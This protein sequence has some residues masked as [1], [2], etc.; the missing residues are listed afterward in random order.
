[1]ALGPTPFRN[2]M[3]PFGGGG[4]TPFAGRGVMRVIPPA[5]LNASLQK[6]DEEK[7]KA[8][9]ISEEVASSL[10]GFIRTQ[11]DEFK[12]HR[13]GS[14]G[15]SERLLHCL[16]VFNGQYDASKIQEIKQFGGSEVYARL[17]SMKCRGA[18][19]L[20]RDVYL[21]NERPW[22][23]EPPDDPDVP[24]EIIAAISQLVGVEAQHQAAAGEP[25][26]AT[27]IRDRTFSLMEAARQAA[28]KRAAAQARVAEDKIDEILSEGKFYEALAAFLVDLPMFPFACIKGPVVK[29]VPTVVWKGPRATIG[30]KPRLFW[31]RV[32]PFDIWWTPGCADIEDAAVIE[33]TRVTRADLNDL[34]DLPGYNVDEIRA[35]LDEYGRGGLNEDWDTTDA[36]RANQESRENPN[37]NRSGLISCLEYHGNVQGRM[38]LEYGMDKK[39][40]PDAMRDYMVQAWLIGRHVIKVQ[41]S[42]S[43][44]KRHPF[45]IT[46][47]E[48]VPGTPVGNGLP[49]ILADIQEVCNATLRALV[50]NLSISSGP[51]VVVNT[52]RLSPDEDGEDLY[53]WKRWRVTSDPMGNNSSAQK[54]IDFFQPNSNAG[55]LLQTYQKFSDLADELSA[56]PKYLS[57]GASGGAGR[58][59]SGL[60]MLMGNASKILQTVAANVDRDVFQGL[61]SN[62]FDMIMLTDQSGMLTGEES[63]RVKGVSV[64]IQRETERSRQIEFLTATANPIDAGIIGV[65][66]RANVLRR[67]ADGIGLDGET[68]VPTEEE[69]KKKQQQMQMAAMAQQGAQAQGGQQGPIMNGDQG[70]RTNSVQ[71]GVG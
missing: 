2:G 13:N 35:V 71:G 11:F 57:G 9:N 29:I 47:F 27:S 7:A 38:L 58:T 44:R 5:Q 6:A 4:A 1:M 21:S 56:I 19:S 50:N 10:A 66:G 15:W 31:Q 64:A 68:I 62:L 22:G 52:D 45:F 8:A 25:V 59:A 63:I 33:R 70:P 54:P 16:R 48:K 65:E 55:E 36:E 17:I 43:P 24:P 20:L 28:K 32:S 26:D 34:L 41:F 42:P 40:I 3:P 60:A 12:R 37:M 67:V 51:Q 18:S 53:P 30:Q 49:D 69:L 39:T 61:L 23:L 14:A 46:S